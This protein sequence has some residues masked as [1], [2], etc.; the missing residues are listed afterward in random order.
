MMAHGKVRFPSPSSSFLFAVI[1]LMMFP[2]VPARADNPCD[3]EGDEPDVIVSN[4]YET[5]RWGVVGDITAFSI[6]TYSCN[7]GTC[8]LNWFPNNNQHPVISGNMYRLMDGRF[9]QIG[10][11]WLK[12]GFYALSGDLCGGGC[13]NTDG[14]HLGVQ[15]S[16]PYSAGLNGEQDRLGPKFEVNPYTGEFPYPATDL[17]LEGNTIYKRLQVHNDDMN[18]ILNPGA[19]YFVDSQYITADDAAAGNQNNNASYRR[20]N[21]TGSE[22]T[23]NLQLVGSTQEEMPAITAWVDNDPEVDL[24]T[25]QVPGDGLVFVAS[26]VTDLGTG[27]W[28]YEYAVQNLNSHRAVREF[29]VEVLPGST[30]ENIGFHDVEYHSGEPTD[31]FDWLF[32]F[33][34]STLPAKIRWSTATYAMNPDAN[35]LLWDTIY[36]FR[37]DLDVPPRLGKVKLGLFR[38]GLPDEVETRTH[39]P[40]LC[41]AD[42]F[43]DLG[44]NVCGCVDDCVPPVTESFCADG[45]DD[46][47]DHFVDCYDDDCC[48]AGACDAFDVDGDNVSICV[49]CNESNSS[50]WTTPGEVRDVG[51]DFVF[52]QL[53]LTWSAPAEP[54]GTA[55]A[56]ETLRSM[57][58]SN[59]LTNT[60]CLVWGSPTVSFYI[61]SEVP[62]AGTS[63]FC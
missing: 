59:F 5:R 10:Q 62:D 11:S 61:D 21:I 13:I 41:N 8:W 27:M 35:A 15:C 42:G 37:F 44:E 48:V 23:Y 4:I 50:I 22:P 32:E 6:G 2:V 36:N 43:C 16:D 47:C 18:P 54:G 25:I 58:P 52:G 24:A 14:T 9:E 56:Y 57:N 53:A 60:T 12:H 17:F 39:V 38:P 28:H 29:S 51:F 7:I 46:D 3:Q 63:G 40:S 20:V 31:G 19:L 49:D 26:K 34:D 55:P 30:V 1:L 33:D 45:K